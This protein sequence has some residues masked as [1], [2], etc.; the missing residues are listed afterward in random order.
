MGKNDK[1][2]S[3]VRRV[4]V[5]AL[6]GAVVTTLL[7]ICLLALPA[8]LAASGRAGDGAQGPMVVTVAFIAS[9]AGA[10]IAR[11]WTRQAALLTC[12]GTALA[13]ILARLIIGLISQGSA[14]LDRLDLGISAAILLAAAGVGAVKHRKRRS[15]R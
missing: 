11:L 8:M 4:A 14:S 1:M 12:L 10:F 13:A 6:M 15:K 5:G 7:S 2:I 9:C 3:G